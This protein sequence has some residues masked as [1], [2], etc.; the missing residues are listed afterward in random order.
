MT[1]KD[2]VIEYIKKR[3]HTEWHVGSKIFSENQLVEYC[4]VSKITVRNAIAQLCNEN[5][6]EK[7]RGSGTYVKSPTGDSRK[8][9]IIILTSIKAVT[10]A[11]RCVYRYFI[12][13]INKIIKDAGYTPVCYIGNTELNIKD[14]IPEV[15]EN[16]VGSVFLRGLPDDLNTIT[17]MK[18]PNVYTLEPFPVLFPSVI[19]DYTDLFIKISQLID[20]YSLND[21]AVFSIEHTQIN[22]YRKR[23]IQTYTDSYWAKYSPT[24]FPITTDNTLNSQIFRNKMKSLK[25]IPD[26]IIFLDDT[27]YNACLPHFPEFDSILKETKIITHSSGNLA[28]S[29]R[30]RI[31]RIEFDLNRCAEETISLLQKRIKGEFM[32]RFSTLIEADVINEE[33][34]S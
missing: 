34:F 8:K 28:H 31:C 17:E 1:K 19:I 7:R 23:E 2:T 27:I 14:S 33:I 18:I 3:I 11:T 25:K 6:L 13:I 5:I 32:N 15:L 20:R 9:N 24:I 29:D 30:Y 21:I 4:H 22:K 10:G 26:A 12:E 16:T